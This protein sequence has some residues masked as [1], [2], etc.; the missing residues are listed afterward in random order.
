MA[1]RRERYH[2]GAVALNSRRWGK[3]AMKL[4]QPGRGILLLDGR[5]QVFQA[6]RLS[7]EQER[8]GLAIKVDLSPLNELERSLVTYALEQMDGRFVVNKLAAA[9]AGQGVTSHQVKILSQN[10]EHRGWLTS[11]QHATDAR[12]VTPEL[13]SL[14]GFSR[15]GAQEAQAHTGGLEVAQAVRTISECA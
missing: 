10:W 8:Q 13:R 1:R 5:Y 6:Y 3:Q 15:T 11:P 7:P 14:A 9:F 12:R 4:R 2:S